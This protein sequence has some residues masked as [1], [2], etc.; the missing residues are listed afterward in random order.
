M[1]FDAPKVKH[2]ATGTKAALHSAESICRKNRVPQTLLDLRDRIG[3][4]N[5]DINVGR[6]NLYPQNA[7]QQQVAKQA[8][9]DIRSPPIRQEA[10]KGTEIASRGRPLKTT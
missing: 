5:Y 1:I 4:E 6:L 7:L 3:S 2:R 9:H 10:N 8:A